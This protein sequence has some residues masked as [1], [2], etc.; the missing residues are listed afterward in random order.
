MAVV[1]HTLQ[2]GIGYVHNLS[3][4][5]ALYTTFARASN[6]DGARVAVGGASVGAGVLNLVFYLRAW[7]SIARRVRPPAPEVEPRRRGGGVRRVPCAWKEPTSFQ[8]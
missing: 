3:K 5:T 4:R 6:H 1:P 7:S 2:W 8:T